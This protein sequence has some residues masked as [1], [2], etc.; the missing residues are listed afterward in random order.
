MGRNRLHPTVL[1]GDA[2]GRAVTVW[3]TAPAGWVLVPTWPCPACVGNGEIMHDYMVIVE[4]TRQ[5]SPILLPV[6]SPTA[7]YEASSTAL[8]LPIGLRE[9]GI[10][11]GTLARVTGGM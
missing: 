5:Q 4:L 9:A 8:V 1:R 3:S 11:I 6:A 7:R 2:D 10:R